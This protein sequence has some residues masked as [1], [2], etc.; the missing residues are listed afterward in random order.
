MKG[1]F[2][3]HIHRRKFQTYLSHV[4]YR[5]MAGI[6]PVYHVRI[7]NAHI[8]YFFCFE[9]VV[10][11]N[12]AKPYVKAFGE[13]DCKKTNLTMTRFLYQVRGEDG[14]IVYSYRFG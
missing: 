7:A 14:A 6:R 5:R 1:V 11:A 2:F 12:W 3:L 9:I 8:F 13:A 4:K 10:G